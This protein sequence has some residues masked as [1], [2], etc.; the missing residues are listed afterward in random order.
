MVLMVALI[1]IFES[2]EVAGL[3]LVLLTLSDT[4]SAPDVS[5]NEPASRGDVFDFQQY[6][7]SPLV[8][9][10]YFSELLF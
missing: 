1:I 10:N 8:Y 3:S 7:M 5:P 6:K 2:E 9:P 4:V